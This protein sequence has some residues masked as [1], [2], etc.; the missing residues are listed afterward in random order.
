[1]TP[2]GR[3]RTA[4]Q[5]LARMLKA[6]PSTAVQREGETLYPLAGLNVLAD[7]DFTLSLLDCWSV[8]A[9][10]LCFYG[11]RIADEGFLATAIEPSSIFYMAQA[12]GY[13]S[14]P[15][16]SASTW[17]QFTVSSTTIPQDKRNSTSVLISSTNSAVVQSIPNQG[18]LPIIFESSYE[19]ELRLAWNQFQPFQP[20]RT[21]TPTLAPGMTGIRLQGAVSSLQAGDLILITT[22]A[23]RYLRFLD[24]VNLQRAQNYTAVTWTGALELDHESAGEL[25]TGVVTFRQQ[26]GLFARRSLAWD[27]ASDAIRGKAGTPAGGVLALAL[28]LAA[29]SPSPWTSISSEVLAEPV[30]VLLAGPGDTLFAAT[31]GGIFRTSGP[32]L[33]ANWTSMPLTPSR[34]DLHSLVRDDRGYLFAGGTRGAISFSTDNGQSWHS[35]TAPIGAVG[36]PKAA[37]KPHESLWS[38]ILNFFGLTESAAPEA[39]A[40]SEPSFDGVVRAIASCPYAI[41][42]GKLPNPRYIFV[43]TDLGVFFMQE[44]GSAWTPCSTGLPNL[45]SDTGLA[46]TV[47]YTFL[48]DGTTLYAGTDAGLYW[49]ETGTWQSAKFDAP[50]QPAVFSLL[51]QAGQPFAGTSGG[52]FSYDPTSTI[53]GGAWSMVSGNLPSGCAVWSLAGGTQG[54]FILAG[55]DAGVFRSTEVGKGSIVWIPLDRQELALFTIDSSEFIQDLEKNVASPLLDSLFKANGAPLPMFAKVESCGENCWVI[56][57]PAP[58][59]QPAMAATTVALILQDGSS[60]HISQVLPISSKQIQTVAVGPAGEC[61][62]AAP[63]GSFLEQQWPG[64]QLNGTSIPLD[65]IVSDPASG[66]QV[67]LID[68][69]PG[70][71][72]LTA[73]LVSAGQTPY[74]SFGRQATVTVLSVEPDGHLGLLHPRDTTVLLKP[75]PLALYTPEAPLFTVLYGD[76]LNLKGAIDGLRDQQTLAITGLSP[77]VIIPSAGGVIPV[78][79]ATGVSMPGPSLLSEDVQALLSDGNLLWAAANG[80]GVYYRTVNSPEPWT[81]IADGLTSLDLRCLAITAA[82]VWAGTSDGVFLLDKDSWVA[83]NKPRWNRGHASAPRDAGT[84]TVDDKG[85]LF[86]GTETDGVCRHSP[87]DSGW[88][89]LAEG[90]SVPDVRALAAHKGL[91]YIG[92][93]SGVYKVDV[94]SGEGPELFGY[95]AATFHSPGK[96]LLG[97]AR[98]NELDVTALA[99]LEQNLYAGTSAGSVL[100]IAIDPEPQPAVWSTMEPDTIQNAVRCIG[101]DGQAIYAG[102]GGEG[103]FRWS[104]EHGWMRVFASASNDVSAMLLGDGERILAGCSNST[105]LGNASGTPI[106]TRPT[107]LFKAPIDCAA[108][109]DLQTLSPDLAALFQQNGSTLK[110]PA[111]SVLQPGLLWTIQNG[112]TKFVVRHRDLSLPTQELDV[113]QAPVLAVVSRASASSLHAALFLWT[114][115]DGADTGSLLAPLDQVLVTPGMPGTSPRAEIITLVDAIVSP[116][117]DFTHCKLANPLQFLYDPAATTLSGNLVY[118]TQGVNVGTEVL[119]SGDATVPNQSFTLK[120]PPLTY[121]YSA[122]PES[123]L[124][125][126]LQVFVGANA[127]ASHPAPAI[128]SAPALAPATPSGQLWTEV[129]ALYGASSAAQVYSLSTDS[130]GNTRVDFGDGENGCRLPT[131]I[132]NVRATYRTGIGPDGNV[133]TASLIV[134]RKRPLGVTAVS[135]PVAA[136]GGSN[137]E[138]ITSIRSRLNFPTRSIDRIV[139]LSDYPNF[140][141]AQANV[142]KARVDVI[143]PPAQRQVIALSLG[144]RDGLPVDKGAIDALIKDIGD[145]R[146]SQEPFAVLGFTPVSFRIKVTIEFQGDDTLI[147]VVDALTAAFSF[148][149]REFGQDVTVSEIT[150]VIQRVPGVLWVEFIAL[151]FA[152]SPPAFSPRLAAQA[153]RW[154]ERSQKIRPA[155]LLLLDTA[156]L[157]DSLSPP[158]PAGTSQ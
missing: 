40:V 7:Q 114:L 104:P 19:A 107:P 57:S 51:L 122:P 92:T 155:E 5:F 157:Y 21:D 117:G 58:A 4:A 48:F 17:L 1:M 62:C 56:H 100:R 68:S 73:T 149:Q 144:G 110:D 105:V 60:L 124:D 89:V 55:T 131:G 78:P 109:L 44:G 133:P 143:L 59:G 90:K 113:A 9:D 156:S 153:A 30:R 82:G 84:F 141:L 111:V 50:T 138:D 136:S 102:T 35:L 154:D 87:D 74:Q 128:L 119:G 53:A 26:A 123:H 54:G 101:F 81:L 72:A 69:T 52:L 36:Q 2:E 108:Q 38:R 130:Q 75:V 42:S 16:V 67:A 80:A 85:N 18:N 28:P 134:F 20:T 32:D 97:Q 112:P 8:V 47:V 118:A 33:A 139:A 88:T 23:S 98:R 37:G 10:I 63:C 45:N 11:A 96:P 43:G 93:R 25:I 22:A 71:L 126:S 127:S 145:K 120:R 140:C 14:W 76:T 95:T 15:G 116:T 83:P 13:Q 121:T 132:D 46:G 99:V 150:A 115:N 129:P 24:A 12:L 146:A 61:F 27:S 41:A 65:R 86:A 34:Q 147:H 70:G 29:V 66:D 91:L 125:C 31:A 77:T 106:R 64:F 148:D 103:I 151:Y 135:N 3:P 6:L 79:Q 94:S 49:L 137:P 142:T 152:D 158:D 39:A